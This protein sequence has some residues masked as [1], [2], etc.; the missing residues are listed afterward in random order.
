MDFTGSGTPLT[1]EGVSKVVGELGAE[2]EALWAVL[3][4]ETTGCGFSADRRPK[5][6]FERHVFSRLTGGRYDDSHPDI[7]DPSAGGYGPSGAHQYERLQ[8]AMA[9]DSEAA[10]KS[11][12]WGLG[13][14]MGENHASAGFAT[15]EEM[16]EAFVEAEDAQLAG[17][18]AFI[19][20][21]PLKRALQT[22]N[23]PTFARL[24]NGLS[25]AE[26]HYDEHLR[27]FYRQYRSSGTPNLSLRAAQVLL[28]YHGLDPGGIDGVLGP[29]TRAALISFQ[30]ASGLPQTGQ[31]DTAT[32]AALEA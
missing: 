12:S 9:L 19:A 6:L 1:D 27:A 20:G 8:S 13:Q 7:S 16:V 17:M 25:Y 31:P 3:A 30:R 11:C 10:L 5:I 32:L 26:N 24:Y 23:W 2:R 22:A 21:S 15:V 4:V 14:I 18:G 28:G 29:Q